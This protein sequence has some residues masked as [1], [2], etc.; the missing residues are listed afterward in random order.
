MTSF[1][2]V[3]NG[4]CSQVEA[5]DTLQEFCQENLGGEITVRA[6]FAD[7]DGHLERIMPV[8]LVTRAGMEP[9]SE[10]RPEGM[11]QVNLNCCFKAA[12]LRDAAALVQIGLEERVTDAVMKDPSIGGL[13]VNTE[14][15]GTEGCQG[16]FWPF[17]FTTIRL[18]IFHRRRCSYD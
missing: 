5:D 3:L 18:S 2:G 9:S 6:I 10:T 1:T 7:P 17:L 12:D 13:A 16:E 4:L 14:L 8:V 11:H 15:L